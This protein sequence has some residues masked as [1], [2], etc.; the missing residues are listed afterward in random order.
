MDSKVKSPCIQ[1]CKYD[2]NEICQG[3]HRSMEEITQWLFMTDAQKE[4]VL[5]NVK[6]RMNEVS[7]EKNDYDYYV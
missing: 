2:K 7:R 5:E 6:Q 3:C 4:V 1:V